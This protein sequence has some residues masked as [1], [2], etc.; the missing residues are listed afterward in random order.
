V[1][2]VGAK[3]A[4][5]PDGPSRRFA[6]TS[7]ST[8]VSALGTSHGD[9]TCSTSCSRYAR[10]VLKI[11]ACCESPHIYTPC[12]KR[13]YYRGDTLKGRLKHTFRDPGRFIKWAR[14]LAEAIGWLHGDNRRYAHRDINP[15]QV[16]SERFLPWPVALLPQQVLIDKEDNVRLGDFGMATTR[17]EG[18]STVVTDNVRGTPGYVPPGAVH[19]DGVALG[20]AA[21]WLK[22]LFRACAELGPLK[23]DRQANVKV[24]LFLSDIYQLGL[25]FFAM[26]SGEMI[27]HKHARG[28]GCKAVTELM[29]RDCRDKG[30]TPDLDEIHDRV[31]RGSDLP[32]ELLGKMCSVDPHDRP[33]M[34][35]VITELEAAYRDWRL[36]DPRAS[37]SRSSEVPA[38]GPGL[39]SSVNRNYG[40][41]ADPRAL[42]SSAL[43][44]PFRSG[45]SSSVNKGYGSMDP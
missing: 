3:G 32:R 20:P 13:Q 36:V 1:S 42:K 28:K 14:Q 43:E 33:R 27:A 45:S 23:L 30:W 15:N 8:S 22:S 41:L 24:N 9:K 6:G 26:A 34:P 37:K 5:S 10:V 31:L 35:E 2:V 11:L 40:S 19:T 18:E 25:M 17:P 4:R 38:V 7:L 39:R 21:I 29:L 16:S 44:M 12:L